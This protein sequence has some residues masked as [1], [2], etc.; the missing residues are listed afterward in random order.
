MDFLRNALRICL[1]LFLM[2][3]AGTGHSQVD[4]R[5]ILAGVIQQLTTGNPNASWYGQQLWQT[6]AFQTNNTGVYQQLVFAGPVSNIQFLG[7]QALP[8][9]NIYQLRSQHANGSFT[10]LMGISTLTNRIE[11]M[12]V[13]PGGTGQVPPGL[14]GTGTTTL[15]LPPGGGGTTSGGGTVSG[16]PSTGGASGTSSA[17]QKFPELC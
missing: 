14:P 3:P 9:G 16:G 6:I 12:N 11:Y 10:W 5:Q 15:P 4:P 8:S 1:L 2:V 13:T 17:C 7:Q